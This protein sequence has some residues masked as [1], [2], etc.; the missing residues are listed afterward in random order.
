VSAANDAHEPL[1]EERHRFD[2]LR[3]GGK[4]PDR[5]VKLP[6]IER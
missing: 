5:E 2:S 4:V 1:L 6:L 3:Q